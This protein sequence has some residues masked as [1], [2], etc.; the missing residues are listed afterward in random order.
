MKLHLW[1]LHVGRRKVYMCSNCGLE[2]TAQE[3]GGKL[4]WETCDETRVRLVMES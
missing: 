1:V 2:I 4:Q 3:L